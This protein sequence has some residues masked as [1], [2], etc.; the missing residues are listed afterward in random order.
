MNF[1][2]FATQLINLLIV[3]IIIA[4]TSCALILPG[5]PTNNN[6]TPV[7]N[8]LIAPTETPIEIVLDL[9]IPT[10]RPTQ[11]SSPTLT[12]P[13]PYGEIIFLTAG[14]VSSYQINSQ[15]IIDLAILT[16]SDILGSSLTPD[17]NTLAYSTKEG[18]YYLDLATDELIASF[19]LDDGSLLIPRG[20]NPHS[21]PGRSQLLVS[22]QL[23]NTYTFSL[24]NQA[25]VINWQ[26]LPNPPNSKSYGCD[27]G[28]AW[29][30]NGDQI[31]I[32]GLNSSLPCSSNPGL[33][34]IN[35]RRGL[36]YQYVQQEI[37][38]GLT[39][40]NKSLAGTR[41]PAWN[42]NGE[43]FY[44]SMDIGVVTALQFYSQ[45]F[46][47][48]ENGSNLT[49]I[50]KNNQGIAAFPL[51]TN[52][53]TLFYSLNGDSP[54]T[55]GIYQYNHT[56][57]ESQLL[58]VGAGLCP[59]NLSQDGSL[60]LFGIKCNEMGGAIEFRLLDLLF[61]DDQTII[62]SLDGKPVQFLGWK[63]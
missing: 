32:S 61:N 44:F 51:P 18:L 45:L 60:L 16:S 22:K 30:P 55:D 10:P 21:L 13:P 3:L 35:N 40:K 38:N 15:T 42:S 54:Q 33:T 63:K 8:N 1:R 5:N 46:Q 31:A 48:Q 47:I 41:T 19:I 24:L 36:S 26:D 17:F 7:D 49:Q 12:S 2:S 27:S 53:G 6:P 43:V 23:R 57:G 50:S 25:P 4:T 28:L 59:I 56:T 39:D 20:F 11:T 37:S 14:K 34:V 9:V 62:R 58:L 52:F 29:A